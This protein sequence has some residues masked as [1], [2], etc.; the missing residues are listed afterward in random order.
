MRSKSSLAAGTLRVFFLG[1]FLVFTIFPLY[2]ITITS[3]KPK[4]DIFTVPSQYWI[5]N[6]TLDNYRNIFKIS[7]FHVYIANSLLVSALAGLVVL[8]ISI[9]SGYVLS[10][11]QFR[12]KNQILLAFFIT[13]M[14]P[15]FIAL[16]PLYSL[17]TNL[18]LTNKLISLVIVYTVMMIPFSTIMLKGFF[19]RIPSSL[20]EAAIID[21]C[22]R[23]QALRRVII[24]VMLPGI[25]ATFIFTFV[26]CWN[27]LFLSVMFIDKETSKT[28]PVAMNSFI[29]KYDIDWGAMSAATVL[30]VLPTFILFAIAQRF[31][32]EGLTEGSVKG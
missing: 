13:Q 22:T 21:G 7:H 24:P 32:V 15:F 12:G 3:F 23:L 8:V 6:F 1:I 28:I 25:S 10:R 18:H 2:W 9:L 11:Y 29:T 17:M 30:S 26:Q 20:E 16:V 31:I 5:P 19:E 4:K 27:E 14:V